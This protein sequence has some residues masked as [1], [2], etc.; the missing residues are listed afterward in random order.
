MKKRKNIKILSFVAIMFFLIGFYNTYIYILPN[1]WQAAIYKTFGKIYDEEKDI[2]NYAMK[3]E[4]IE[5]VDKD[6]MKSEKGLVYIVEYSGDPD[7]GW[8]K[9]KIKTINDVNPEYLLDYTQDKNI[10]FEKIG[11]ISLEDIYRYY[12]ARHNRG[13]IIFEADGEDNYI[14]EIYQNRDNLKEKDYYVAV[15]TIPR[16]T[17]GYYGKEANITS[18]LAEKSVHA[19]WENSSKFSP[20]LGNI[21]T[22]E[23]VTMTKFNNW[24]LL[25]VGSIVSIVSY[26]LSAYFLYSIFKERNRRRMEEEG[27]WEEIKN[28]EK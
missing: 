10:S 9:D 23:Y 1:A 27:I 4:A 15:T 26:A 5:Q 20:G 2:G 7:V 13:I 17:D 14:K 16:Y 28:E 11:D 24:E 22:Q 6:D 12:L 3:I 19:R 25:S 21:S 8:D 18:A